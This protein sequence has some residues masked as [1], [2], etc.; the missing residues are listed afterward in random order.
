M[1][2]DYKK[3]CFGDI[4]RFG[5]LVAKNILPSNHNL[6]QFFAKN[7]KLHQSYLF[8]RFKD[9]LSFLQFYLSTFFILISFFSSAQ[10]YDTLKDSR[11]SRWYMTI[12]IGNQVWMAEN[13]N[14]KPKRGSSCYADDKSNCSKYGRLYM[15]DVISKVCPA[16]WHASTQNEWFNLVNFLGGPDS[17]GMHLKLKSRL[18]VNQNPRDDNSSGFSAIPAG[19]RTIS[20]NSQSMGYY[21]YFWIDNESGE[22]AWCASITCT[23]KNVE[24]NG[25][26]TVTGMSLRCVK[27]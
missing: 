9:S 6:S 27:D 1:I 12:K 17:A 25:F 15:W 26:S 19:K 8:I 2:F 5:V 14:Y 13:L 3:E 16:G 18:W 11:D 24:F 10:I 7:T 22:F 23:G 20:N 4:W 21:A